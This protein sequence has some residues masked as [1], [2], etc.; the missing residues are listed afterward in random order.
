MQEIAVRPVPFFVVVGLYIVFLAIIG[1]YAA[2]KTSNIRDYFVLSGKAGVIVSGIAYA[3]TQYS[4]GT[5]LGTPG[6]I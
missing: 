4:M 5:F 2:K 3:T 6:T 1:V